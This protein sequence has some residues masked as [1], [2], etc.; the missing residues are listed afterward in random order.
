[1]NNQRRKKRTPPILVDSDGIPINPPIPYNI[2]DELEKKELLGCGSTAVIYGDGPDQVQKRFFNDDWQ[3]KEEV[4]M[5][6]KIQEL[7]KEFP[8]RVPDIYGTHLHK[9]IIYMERIH[10]PSNFAPHLIHLALGYT[11]EDIDCLWYI[12]GTRLPRGFYA[13]IETIL[14]L[15]HVNYWSHITINYITHLMGSIIKHLLSNCIIPIGIEWSID[16][17][18]RIWLS[19]FGSCKYGY[20]EPVQYFY[21]GY[22]ENTI[23]DIY[24]PIIQQNGYNS[25][26]DGYF[27]HPIE[28]MRDIDDLYFCISETYVDAQLEERLKTQTRDSPGD[29]TEDEEYK[30]KQEDYLNSQF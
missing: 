20:A 11:G 1:M 24:T 21:M 26:Y 12:N 18:G 28:V 4:D 25:Y 5:Q 15:T 6:R 8:V 14:S 16:R 23:R 13:G 3:Y 19:D 29:S 7:L 30:K 17:N 27:G 9:P 22:T 2:I 10:P